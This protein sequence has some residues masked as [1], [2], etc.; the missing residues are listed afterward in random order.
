MS[1]QNIQRETSEPAFKA[2]PVEPIRVFRRLDPSKPI[3]LPETAANRKCTD[4]PFLLIFEM[5]QIILII[6]SVYIASVSDWK[7]IDLGADECKNTCGMKNVVKYNKK[8]PLKDY[9]GFP[10]IIESEKRCVSEAECKERN[11]VVIYKECLRNDS[12]TEEEADYVRQL[13]SWE[14]TYK[15]SLILLVITPIIASVLAMM[16]FL[17]FRWNAFVTFYTFGALSIV[18]FLFVTP[19]LWYIIYYLTVKTNLGW[20]TLWYLYVAA[21]VCTIITITL[22]ILFLWRR[23]Q[24][25]FLIQLYREAI[26]AIFRSNYMLFAPLIATLVLEVL[27]VIAFFLFGFSQSV[28]VPQNSSFPVERTFYVVFMLFMGYWIFTFS[29]GCQNMMTAGVVASYYFSRDKN[30]LENQYLKF[31]KIVVRYHLGTVA[32]G[33]LTITLVSILKFVINRFRARDSE[34]CNEVLYL[35]CHCMEEFLHYVSV[36]AYIMTAIHGRSFLKSGKRAVRVMWLHFLDLVQ[37]DAFNVLAMFSAGV[38]ITLV[39][40]FIAYAVV[41]EEH[42]TFILANL[43]IVLGLA[44]VTLYLFLSMI[45]VSIGTL[46]LCY[47]EDRHMNDD[48]DQPYYMSP[49]LEEAVSEALEFAIRTRLEKALRRGQIS[50]N[51]APNV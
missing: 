41:A 26:P 27:A 22:P 1:I 11:W 23:Q 50:Q 36:K 4:I 42:E 30:S 39:C 14:K 49:Q 2:L 24:T 6:S 51:S 13:I 44:A 16:V 28:K 37:V 35:L 17:A 33:S 25:K 46:F 7:I 3:D 9:T 32:A 40:L 29:V 43:I 47:C 12:L 5:F 20:Q 21:V 38:I 15:T 34:W 31:A 18:M 8:C 48:T 45:S 10:Y 19:T